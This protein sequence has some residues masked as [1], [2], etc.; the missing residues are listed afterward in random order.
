MSKEEII[1]V[2]GEPNSENDFS[3]SEHDPDNI[4]ENGHFFC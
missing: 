2:L 4:V 3:D 1:R